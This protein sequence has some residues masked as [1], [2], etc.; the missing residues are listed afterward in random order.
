MS[1]PPIEPESVPTP[2][3]APSAVPP[4]PPTPG[5]P[6]PAYGVPQQSYGDQY[7]NGAVPPAPGQYAGQPYQPQQPYQSPYGAPVGYGA[8]MYP[9]Q[10]SPVGEFFRALFSTNFKVFVTSKLLSI[11]Y[12]L[13]MIGLGLTFILGLISVIGAVITPFGPGVG[14]GIVTVLVYLI[15]SAVG[16]ALTLAFARVTLEFFAATIQTA[17]NT[18]RLVADA[19]VSKG[20]SPESN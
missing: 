17:E 10:P 20:E 3:T 9:P 4:A 7:G 18:H 11:L 15:V 8:P 16:M 19:E 14:A 2:P 6:T 5:Q 13:V 12:V 1:Y